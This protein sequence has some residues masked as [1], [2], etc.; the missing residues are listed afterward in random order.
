[1]D[2]RDADTVDVALMLVTSGY[3]LW[4]DHH[5]EHEPDWT[6][7]E[8]VVGTAIC[9]TAAGLRSRALGGDWRAHERSVIRAFV[10]GGLPIVAGEVSQALRGWGE[11]ERYRERL[12]Q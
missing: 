2:E 11:R 5:K 9:L 12:M 4:L 10:L 3:A 7:L 1:M 6:W 8:V